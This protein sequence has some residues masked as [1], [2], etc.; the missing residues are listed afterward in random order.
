MKHT[1][2]DHPDYPFLLKV[3]QSIEE[4]VAQINESKRQKDNA[5]KL[6]EIADDLEGAEVCKIQLSLVPV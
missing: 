1:S 6:Q 5:F 3:T 2:H 4:I